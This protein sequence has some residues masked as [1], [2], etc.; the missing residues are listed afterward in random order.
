MAP[1]VELAQAEA[2]LATIVESRHSLTCILEAVELKGR[3]GDR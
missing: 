2:T 3:D 1:L